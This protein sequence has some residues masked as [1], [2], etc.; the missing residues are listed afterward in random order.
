M[1]TAQG[2]AMYCSIQP[3]IASKISCCA[4]WGKRREGSVEYFLEVQTVK[5][6]VSCCKLYY[7]PPNNPSPISAQPYGLMASEEGVEPALRVEAL[8]RVKGFLSGTW[9]EID[10]SKIIIKKI[11]LA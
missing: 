4:G 3:I 7:T 11:R 1:P 10:E 5:N 9:K 2:E 8:R 6:L